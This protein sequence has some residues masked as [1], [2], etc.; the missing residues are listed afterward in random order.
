MSTKPDTFD[1]EGT[2]SSFAAEGGTP[3]RPISDEEW[4]RMKALISD[5]L[6]RVTTPLEELRG[7]GTLAAISHIIQRGDS[8][9]RSRLQVRRRARSIGL[10]QR[11]I[12][13]T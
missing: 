4:E 1:R 7:S 5:Q 9:K 13:L 12:E 10:R 11:L 3:L 8:C 6:H 2:G